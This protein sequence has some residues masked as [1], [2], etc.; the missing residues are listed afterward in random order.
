[1]GLGVFAA[2]NDAIDFDTAVLVADEFHAKG[3]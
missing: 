2:I 3:E 1:M